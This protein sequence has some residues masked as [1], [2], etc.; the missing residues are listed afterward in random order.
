MWEQ[1]TWD[2]HIKGRSVTIAWWR[3][4]RVELPVQRKLPRIYYKFSQLFYLTWL[5]SADRV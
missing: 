1:V 5:A 4:G 3:R 2:W